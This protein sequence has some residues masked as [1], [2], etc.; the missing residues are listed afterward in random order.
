MGRSLEFP[1]IYMHL[2]CFPDNLSMNN[3]QQTL[4]VQCSAVVNVT[5][6]NNAAIVANAPNVNVAI[7]DRR[8]KLLAQGYLI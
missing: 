6:T 5:N 4:L 2:Q 8:V 3:Q 1:K 7:A